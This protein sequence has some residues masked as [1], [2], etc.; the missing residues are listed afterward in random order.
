MPMIPS[1]LK[2]FWLLAVVPMGLL[3]PPTGSVATPGML[4][5]VN[6]GDATLSLLD[7]ETG[8]REV[9]IA[10]GVPKMVAHEVAV[11]PDG[12]MAYL[13]LYGD[14]GVGRPGTDGDTMLVVDLVK[15]AIVNRMSFGRGVRPHC[16]VYEPVTGLLYVTTELGESVTLIDPKTL[17][18]VGTIATKQAQSHML[19]LSHD[20]RRGYTANVGAGTV[21]VLD[22]TTRRFIT[23]IPISAMT[24]R[25]S[26]SNDDATVITADQT[27]PRMALIDTATN[28]L[29]GWLPLPAV[30]YGSVFTKDGQ[31]LLVTMPG[32][33]E[34]AVVDWKTQ[35]V[36]H[37]ISVGPRPQEV[38][39]RPDGKVAYV[40]CFGGRQAVA[41]DVGTWTVTE[42]MDS[43]E[44]ADGMAWAAGTPAGGGAGAGG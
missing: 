11:S 29:R 33:G 42:R 13:P 28:R 36:R 24:Q 30:G 34:L 18:I 6:Q 39:L 31:W 23:S 15:R 2:S 17:R 32:A 16:I 22:L 20:G 26:I 27:T 9:S 41:V 21:S 19:A 43:G 44:K 14:A 38:I 25:I 35:E 4:L 5:V 10:E 7:P 3:C 37:V 8:Q 40:S 12:R 1:L